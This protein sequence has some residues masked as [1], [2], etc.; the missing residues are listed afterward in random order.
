MPM[1]QW[2]LGGF[3]HSLLLMILV[4][5]LVW[6]QPDQVIGAPSREKGLAQLSKVTA[7]GQTFEK[8]AKRPNDLHITA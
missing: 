6:L 2:P 3:S 8:T 4:Q 5:E 1:G 7:A